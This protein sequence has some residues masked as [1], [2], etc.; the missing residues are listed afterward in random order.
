M[1]SKSLISILGAVGVF[2]VA[3]PAATADPVAD[4][5]K[6]KTV[7]VTLPVGP[8]G[9]FGLHGL[10]LA[11]HMGRFLP[12]NPNIVPDYQPGAGG[13]KASNFVYNVAAKDGTNI[14]MP[15]PAGVLAQH[16][17][18]GMVKFDMA[19]FQYIGRMADT[20]RVLFVWHTAP[21]QTIDALKKTQ[22]VLSASGKSSNTYIHP[23]VMNAVVGTK[24][25]VITGYTGAAA[26]AK[27][28][29]NGEVQGGTSS[30]VNLISARPHWLKENKIRM[31]VQLGLKPIPGLNDVPMLHD[32]VADPKDRKVV[33]YME[34]TSDIGYAFMTPPGVPAERVAAL[35]KAFAAMMKDPTF[36]ADAEKRKAVLNYASG[37]EL[38]EIVKDALDTPPELVERFMQMSKG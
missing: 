32:L 11:E 27:A 20:T 3:A 1:I 4:F 21:A 18:K 30:W 6:G 29:E 22:V 13:T 26:E 33:Q 38:A 5:Y 31:I 10:L 8:G 19:K 23:V 17:R 15:Y 35:R 25:K 9:T 7:K 16:T 12:G 37:E 2:A 36:I 28:I 24:F 34:H 14:A